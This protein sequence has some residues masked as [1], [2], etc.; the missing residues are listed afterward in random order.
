MANDLFSSGSHT[1][2]PLAARMRPRTLDEFVGQQHIVGPGR[3]LRRA[4]QAD[5]LSSVI[6]YGPPGTGKT[7]LARVIANTTKSSF[8]SLNAVLA[9]VK[10]VRES[11]A[12]ATE[13]RDLYDR[14]TILFVD[15]VHRWNKAQQDA[16][17]PWVENGTVVLI[18]A[19]TQNP[20]F[21]VNAA[22]VSRSRIFQL[23][24]LTADDLREVVR[25]ALSDPT[26]GYGN[27][28]VRID[29]DALDHLLTVAAGD[30]RALLNALQLAVETTPGQFPPQPQ[31]TIH[32]TRAIAED[33]IQKKAVLYDKE[34]DYHFD[35]I[36]AFIK[37]IRGSDPD[38]ALYWL[39]KMVH[40]GEDPHFI[41][42]RLLIS[43]SEDVGMAAPEAAGVVQSLAEAFDRV[44]MPEGN[45]FLAHATI[46]LATRPKS[47]SA[48]AF[49]DALEAVRSEEST[50]VPTHL[51]SDA[52]DA[53]GFGHGKGYLY[54][55]AYRDHWVAQSYLPTSLQGRLFYQPS[56]Q[57]AEAE[58]RKRLA[59]LRELQLEA[60]S[61]EVPEEVLTYTRHSNRLLDHWVERSSADRTAA[62]AAVRDAVMERLA[63]LRHHRVLLAGRNAG[64]ALWECLRAAPEGTVW[65]LIPA[66]ERREAASHYAAQLPEL[67]RPQIIDPSGFSPSAESTTA[68][69]TELAAGVRFER[70]AVINGFRPSEHA[71]YASLLADGGRVMVAQVIP[72]HGQRLCEL[73]AWPSASLRET[74]AAV[75]ASLYEEAEHELVG[76]DE[77]DVA[78]AVAAAGLE[79]SAT[80]MLETY[81][82]RTIGAQHLKRW[83]E[84]AARGGLAAKLAELDSDVRREVD[85]AVRSSLDGVTVTWRHH[86][87][88][89]T[90]AAAATT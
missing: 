37:S 9:G 8:L 83:L 41:L 29:P 76:W 27:L 75:E 25:Q 45:Y 89:I 18:G 56:D 66:A 4:I 71:F 70:I 90:A 72:R 19:T 40:G 14:R 50:D 82:Q 59:R 1:G 54:P 58:V 36:S 73:V 74:F 3:L 13:A 84:D 62:I 63:P 11:I 65:A 21:E 42:R 46:Y 10:Q 23:V 68:W 64:V 53:A 5:M 51:K 52:R 44:G 34:G 47:N 20:F 88:L 30:A 33:S 39:A 16:L 48:L 77:G 12:Q 2:E 67:E 7:T 32:V 87:V 24:S 60:S 78:A 38:A 43:A 55:H 81:E 26:R 57:G 17:L 86:Y 85:T 61:D 79:V 80:E 69:H 6:F 22:L 15:E 35:V 49:F 28:D 31:T